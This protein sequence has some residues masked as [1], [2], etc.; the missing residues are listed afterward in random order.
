MIIERQH[1]HHVIK[2]KKY[3][4]KYFANWETSANF[5]SSTLLSMTN[6]KSDIKNY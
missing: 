6:T 3:F 5:N 4:A 1:Q 2:H